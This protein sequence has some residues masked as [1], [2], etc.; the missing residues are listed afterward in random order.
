M[1]CR[2]VFHPAYRGWIGAGRRRP[3]LWRV[4][5]GIVIIALCWSLTALAVF[6][7]AD[8]VRLATTRGDELGEILANWVAAG[9]PQMNSIWVIEPELAGLLVVASFSG[10]WLGVWITLRL[11]HRRHLASVLAAPGR[12]HW[13]DYAIGFAIA[14]GFFVFSLF[15]FL[16]AGENLPFSLGGVAAWGWALVPLFLLVG[17][18][19]CGEELLLRGYLQQQLA[20]R[21]RNPLIWLGVPSLLFGLLHWQP[22]LQGI[23]YIAV[24]T[25][26]G[27]AAGVIVW[28]T[29]S[30]AGAMGLHHANNMLN[31]TLTGPHGMAESLRSGG[32]QID[33][34][35]FAASGLLFLALLVLVL[36]RWSP[37]NPVPRGARVLR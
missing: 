14:L 18:Q 12:W 21:C 9:G 37:F 34:A 20:T 13:R 16:I 30:L 1:R 22:G 10:I 31:F 3:A 2:P 17:V 27:L 36:S 33:A 26:F 28:R 23:A 11:L 25:I 29:G 15:G 7:I 4:L 19:A 6:V 32:G 24:T 8:A 35:A 5:L